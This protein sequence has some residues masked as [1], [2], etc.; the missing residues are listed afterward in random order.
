MRRQATPI[1]G[2]GLYFRAIAFMSLSLASSFMGEANAQS[3]P[4]GLANQYRD[5]VGVELSENDSL[6]TFEGDRLLALPAPTQ[7]DL[8]V[9][10]TAGNCLADATGRLWAYD[11]D[12]NHFSTGSRSQHRALIARQ[13]ELI[14]AQAQV[15]AEEAAMIAA[16]IALIESERRAVV[17]Q[18]TR[19]A[20]VDLYLNDTVAALTN[21]VCQP[22]FLEIGLPS[23]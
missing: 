11:P 19:D 18:A 1:S 16:E 21:Q 2:G 7:T 12:R 10:I 8:Y 4:E 15:Q 9:G 13:Q 20:C 5:C 3:L 22:L 17:W 23:D 14:A 6:P